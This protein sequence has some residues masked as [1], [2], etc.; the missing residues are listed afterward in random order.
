MFSL[1][2]RTAVALLVAGALFIEILDA[3]IIT[4]A[5]PIIARDFGVPAAHLSVGVS[6]YLVAVTIFIPISGYM[7]DRFGAR[8]IFIAALCTFMLASVLCA[9]AENV[10]S[11]TAARLLQGI[12]GAMMVPVGRLVVLRDVPKERLVK[13]VAIL[14][15][16][17]LGAPLLGPVLGGWIATHWGWP[18]IFLINLPLGLI[19]LTGALLLLKNYRVDTGPFDWRGFL[20]CGAGFGTL[21]AGL[22]LLSSMNASRIAP[23]LLVATGILLL[24]L[25]VKYLLGAP[26]P[27]LTFRAMQKK[28]F[29]VTVLGGSVIRIAMSSTPFLIPLML[30]LGLGY[31]AVE[32]GTMLLWLFAGNL[33]IKPAT[34]RIMNLFGFKRILIVNAVAIAAGFMALGLVTAATPTWLLGLILFISGMN[35]SVHLTVLNTLNFADIPHTQMRDANT[36][37]AVLMQMNRGLGITVGALALAL[38]SYLA[39]GSNAQPDLMHFHLAMLFMGGLALVSIIDSL[40]LAPNAGN[41]VLK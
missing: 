27:L 1:D 4:T 20:L 7:A 8:H 2:R 22:E 10:Y 19:A 39:G 6:S 25:A 41:A 11:F 5:L 3:T 40:R 23:W 29:R 32:A 38:A 34:T 17:A 14:T 15:W 35:R 13:A 24:V 12:G 21:M 9:L 36:L 26:A 18:W 30:Q 28:T 33:A 37:S 31:T 16:P